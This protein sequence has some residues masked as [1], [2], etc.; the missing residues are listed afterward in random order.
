MDIASGGYVKIMDQRLGVFW[1]WFLLGCF[2]NEVVVCGLLSKAEHGPLS[3][4][5]AKSKEGGGDSEHGQRW[6][7]QWLKDTQSLCWPGP[8]GAWT[9]QPR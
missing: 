6:G 9:V 1:C 5:V 4:A 8:A 3:S 2:F 7:L